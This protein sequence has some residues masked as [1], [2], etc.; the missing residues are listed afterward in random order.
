MD[1]TTTN[2][3]AGP[4]VRCPSCGEMKPYSRDNPFRP[5]CSRG[6]QAIDLGAWA[7]E[8]YRMT[9]AIKP[10]DLPDDLEPR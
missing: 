3:P 9:P 2:A 7:S 10:E 4:L 8:Q 5:F 6:C 1:Q